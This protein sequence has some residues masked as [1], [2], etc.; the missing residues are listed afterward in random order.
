MAARIRSILN[1]DPSTAVD[2]ASRNDL[3]SGDVVTVQSLDAATSYSWSITFAPEGS[4]AAFSGS[5]T[6]PVPGDFTV[7]VEGPY[8]I[9]LVV[10]TGLPT[11]D[12][13]YVRLRYL[14][15]FGKLTLV[16]AGE[17]RDGTGVIPVDVDMEGWANEQNSNIQT[18]KEFIKPLVSSGRLLYVDA[19]VGTE[20][21]AHF[22][23]VQDALDA[24]VANGA[25]SAEPWVVVVRPGRYV[26]NITFPAWV[27]VTGW[28]GVDQSVVLEGTHTVSLPGASDRVVLRHLHVEV[29]TDTTSAGLTKTGNGLLHIRE[30]QAIVNGV[31]LDQGPAL[32]LQAGSLLAQ[33]SILSHEMSG[34]PDRVAFAQTGIN[35]TSR[36][37]RCHITG[38]SGISINP[39][40]LTGV[41][42]S[43]LDCEITSGVGTP[44][45]TTAEDTTFERCALLN[46][47]GGVGVVVNPGASVF[48]GSVALTLRYSRVQDDILFDTT[49]LSGT[50]TLNTGAL[51]YGEII[52]PD[53]PPDNLNALPKAKSHFYDDSWSGIG[54]DNV[55]D[56]IDILSLAPDIAPLV[57]N[58]NIPEIPDDSVSYR[59]WV[60]VTCTLL[61]VRVR[62]MTVNTEGNYTLSVVNDSTTN[63]VL[64]APSFD[65]NTLT[66]GVITTI[67]ITADANDLSFPTLSGWTVTLT[68]DD[69]DFN[70]SDVYVELLF[71]SASGGGP[72]VEDLATTLLIGNFTGGTNIDVSAGDVIEFGASPLA[73]ISDPGTGRIRYNQNTGTFQVSTDGGPWVDIGSGSG[74]GSVFI[75]KNAPA[76]PDTIF[77]YEGWC[78]IEATVTDISVAMSTVNTEGG[79][80][81]VFTNETTGQ[82]MLAGADFDMNTLVA[83]EVTSLALTGVAADLEFE[84]GD[85]WS[86]EFTSDD[87]GFD[88]D[89]IYWSI[90][91]EPS[92][93]SP[94]PPGLAE[95]SDQFEMS[96]VPDEIVHTLWFAP[97]DCEVLEIKVYGAVSPT[98]SGVYTLEVEDMDNANNLLSA[99]TFDMTSL[100]AETLT[101]LTL[102][103]TLGDLLISKGTRV[104]F[105]LVSDDEDLVAAG[106][107]IQIIYRRP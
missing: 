91:F 51:E 9:R 82:S 93:S 24:A 98:T 42:A 30:V 95:D 57:F 47:G 72:I 27:H 45:S 77:R 22:S 44:V 8:L 41:V 2:E 10:D 14:T 102:T 46:P 88:G 74:T 58:K 6:D 54:A 75:H 40:L 87:L 61:A 81:V 53:G 13:Q 52:Y 20:N 62:M 76:L 5:T 35:T 36:F 56:A 49:N 29:N 48:G 79:Y 92:G 65:M 3:S 90:L 43:F 97:Y 67:P 78:P 55:Q 80:T 63:T 73:P 32:L 59:G 21:Y 11:E 15:D 66:P 39:S 86:V 17:R 38:P 7:D 106:V 16:A 1:G 4:T 68:S 100:V 25:S 84:E 83:G 37:E 96:V 104:R 70:G 33:D 103:A 31:D 23:S 19:N 99:S 18:L 64:D 71:N 12:T 105:R 85:Q 107:Y 26:E 50:T 28:P 60:P 34:E 69:P 89:G 101:D 94:T